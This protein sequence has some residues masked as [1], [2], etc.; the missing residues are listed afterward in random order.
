MHIFANRSSLYNDNE[1]RDAFDQK[2]RRPEPYLDGG[3]FDKQEKRG[4]L[5]DNV[6][7]LIAGGVVLFI[8]FVAAAVLLG[9]L[10]SGSGQCSLR[11]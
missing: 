4:K 9:V 6:K 2:L 7:M 8:V 11:S 10:L 1:R 5:S 3:Y